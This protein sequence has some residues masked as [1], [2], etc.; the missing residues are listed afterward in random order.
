LFDVVFR[1]IDLVLSVGI[2]HP[3]FLLLFY[4]PTPS[5]YYNRTLFQFACRFTSP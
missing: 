1:S 5:I 4:L 2:Q 3:S